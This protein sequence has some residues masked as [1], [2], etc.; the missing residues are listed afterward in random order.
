MPVDTPFDRKMKVAMLHIA[1]WFIF[2]MLP[3]IFKPHM[4]GEGYSLSFFINDILIP[5]RWTNALLLIIVFYFNYRYTI[6]KLYFRKRYWLFLVSFVVAFSCF[7]LLNASM[8]PPDVRS[9]PT[10]GFEALG[11]SFNFFMF[12]IVYAASF[13]L[14]IY[15]QWQRTKEEMYS[16]RLS[17]LKAQINPHFLF[18]TLNSIYSLALTKSD[19]TPGAIIRL[20][21]MMRYSVTEAI[22]DHVDLTKEVEYIRNYVELQQLRLPEN[23]QLDLTVDGI[24]EGKK[25]VPLLLIPIIEN[26]FKYGVNPEEDTKIRITIQIEDDMLKLHVVNRKVFVKKENVEQTGIGLS[27]TR[28]RLKMLYPGKHTLTITDNMDDFS[29]SLHIRYL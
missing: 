8:M 18:N 11:N 7:T 9:H 21:G 6:P 29:I 22:Y 2:L 28:Q 5:P 19:K 14:C 10:G 27:T 4:Y 20:S 25:I 26:A 17:F 3:A 23:A 15:E 1:C 12:L 24:A 16:A 13:A